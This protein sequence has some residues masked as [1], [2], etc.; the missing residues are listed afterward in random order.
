MSTLLSFSREQPLTA[1]RQASLCETHMSTP[2]ALRPPLGI[3]LPHL[4]PGVQTASRVLMLLLLLCIANLPRISSSQRRSQSDHHCRATPFR[5]QGSVFLLILS[6][7][8]QT[9]AL[10]PRP[11]RRMQQFTQPNK[12][13][14]RSTSLPPPS[15]Q[16][17]ESFHQEHPFPHKSVANLP[18]LKSGPPN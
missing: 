5:E 7:L 14:T 15:S 17:S 9:S 8:T 6:Y 13:Y 4:S 16:S 12:L 3:L 1:L 2:W 10:H 18:Q 11:L